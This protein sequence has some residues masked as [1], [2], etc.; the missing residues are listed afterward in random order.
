MALTKHPQITV[1]FG[2]QREAVQRRKDGPVICPHGSGRGDWQLL[3]SP[4]QH[5][6][7]GTGPSSGLLVS[8]LLLA[9]LTCWPEVSHGTLSKCR[10]DWE[11]C[12]SAGQPCGAKSQ[13][14]VIKEQ[15]NAWRYSQEVPGTASRH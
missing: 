14:S 3:G 5:E 11:M 8:P 7:E 4:G 15:E 13:S 10:Q 12:S 1:D 9:V 2:V 6:G